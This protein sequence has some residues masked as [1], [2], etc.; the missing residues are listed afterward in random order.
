MHVSLAHQSVVIRSG[1]LL[2]KWAESF[3]SGHVRVIATNQVFCHTCFFVSLPSDWLLGFYQFINHLYLGRL[4]TLFCLV[5]C[6]WYLERLILYSQSGGSFSC[7]ASLLNA[8]AALP[9]CSIVTEREATITERK[10]MHTKWLLNPDM[11]H[12]PQ[13]RLDFADQ[14]MLNTKNVDKGL[15]HQN[16]LV[17]WL[18][19]KSVLL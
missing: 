3:Q 12:I 8:V 16:Y 7:P 1:E 5:F 18:P 13:K 17:A 10:A 19:L 2:C 14:W 11:T 4:L 9:L 15:D 6:F